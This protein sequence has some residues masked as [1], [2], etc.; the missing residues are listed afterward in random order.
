MLDE[1]EN[2]EVRNRRKLME[3]GQQSEHDVSLLDRTECQLLDDQRVAADFVVGKQPDEPRL[4]GVQM[5]DPHRRVNE[6]QPAD[7]LR[8]GAADA[9]ES[10]PPSAAR[11][12][13]LSTRI[14]VC[15]P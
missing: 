4:G 5:V 13:P 7:A 3:I 15:N 1:M 2:F 11:R 9:S 10:V 8:R 12:R 6:D 14:K